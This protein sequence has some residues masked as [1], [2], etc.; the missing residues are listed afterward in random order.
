[1]LCNRL[2]LVDGDSSRLV[3]ILYRMLFLVVSPTSVEHFP[4]RDIFDELLKRSYARFMN[5]FTAPE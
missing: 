1:L 5:A 3:E 4:I 2:G